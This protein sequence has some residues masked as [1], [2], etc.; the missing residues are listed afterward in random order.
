MYLLTYLLTYIPSSNT[1]FWSRC[2][3]RRR[4]TCLQTLLWRLQWRVSNTTVSRHIIA[5]VGN[6][7][8]FVANLTDF[9]AVKK[10]WKAVKIDEII[11]TIGWRVFL[12][13]C[14]SWY[15]FLP[16]TNIWAVANPDKQQR[17]ADTGPKILKNSD[18]THTRRPRFDTERGVSLHT[19]D[20]RQ[21]ALMSDKY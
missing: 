7:I 6:V 5:V 12:R 19:V 1:N 8:H 10:I 4:K 13:Q 20:V 17:R 11:V 2:Y 14:R 16:G 18:Y 9:L 3:L 15:Y 21:K